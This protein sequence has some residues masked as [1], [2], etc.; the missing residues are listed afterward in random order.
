VAAR[1]NCPAPLTEAL[2][3]SGNRETCA[4]DRCAI[5]VMRSPMLPL[6][7]LPV[8]HNPITSQHVEAIFINMKTNMRFVIYITAQNKKE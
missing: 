7:V 2:T 8:P 6:Y 1:A 4:Q 5:G 3:Q